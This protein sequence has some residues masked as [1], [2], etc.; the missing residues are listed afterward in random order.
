MRAPAGRGS[1]GEPRTGVGK[2]CTRAL[3]LRPLGNLPTPGR[4][5]SYCAMHAARLRSIGRK[6]GRPNRLALLRK[7]RTGEGQ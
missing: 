2:R 3:R 7:R 4:R 6:D 1:P 5:F